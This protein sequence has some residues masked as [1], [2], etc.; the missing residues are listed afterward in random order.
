MKRKNQKSIAYIITGLEPDGA[1]H[2]LYRLNQQ[3]V[4][5][6]KYSQHVISL[7]SEGAIGPMIRALGI[8]VI[9]LGMKSGKVN[10]F[11]FIKLV[12]ILRA[13]QPDV[14]HTWMYHADFLGG[15]AAKLAGIKKICWGIR[16]GNL[17]PQHNKKSTLYVIRLCALLSQW[18][19]NK[20]L[21]NSF[22]ALKTH[23]EFGYDRKKIKVIPNG[24]DPQC[25]YPNYESRSSV[26]EELKLNPN[27]V[28][29]GLIA[30]YDIQKNHLGF[31]EA[32]AL[33][34]R[35]RPDVHFLFAGSG[36]DNDNL[37]L[38]NEIR[39][40]GLVD[41]VHLLSIRKDVPRIISSLDLLCSS[42]VGEAF[43]NVIC[44]AM[45]C[46]VP[47]VVTD[48]GDSADIVGDAGIVVPINAMDK[49]AQGVVTLLNM[50]LY[51]F[52]QLKKNVLERVK[53]KYDMT[54]VAKQYVGLYDGLLQA[55]TI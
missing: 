40:L 43:P 42:S 18:I 29:V 7:T 19:P 23:A 50:P 44:E 45:A 15:L 22:Y 6:K 46:G 20:I 2:M 14:V 48:A 9:S 32:V 1:E 41:A 5:T 52:D 30:R 47:C 33:I 3:I 37:E 25:F 39:K 51:E 35:V 53:A 36:V 21:C 13:I 28:L 54:T 49:L 31:M 11:K 26:R 10:V 16:H 55:E 24:Y 8:N 38:V 27:V 17:S 12:K 4:D 34:R